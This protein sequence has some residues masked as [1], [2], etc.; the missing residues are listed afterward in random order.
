[1]TTW[2]RRI[3]TIFTLI[4]ML[5][6]GNTGLPVNQSS[7]T[8][9]AE[10]TCSW[11]CYRGDTRRTGVTHNDCGP[12]SANLTFLW[13]FETISQ[14]VSSPAIAESRVVI[15][16]DDG[17]VHCLEQS[18]GEQLWETRIGKDIHSSPA[19]AMG[20]IFVGSEDG[21]M[22]C[23]DLETGEVVWSFK[24]EAPIHS[25]PVVYN[26]RLYFGSYDFNVYCISPIDG[27]LIWKYQTYG[28]VF[29]SPAV[30]EER[31]YIGSD[32]GKLYCL[33]FKTGEFIWDFETSKK[34]D[35]TPVFVNDRIVFASDSVFCLRADTG[36]LYW[37]FPIGAYGVSSCA[38]A[39]NSVTVCRWDGMLFN[40]GL[41]T[42]KLNW[43]HKIN[44]FAKAPSICADRIYLAT[45][46]GWFSSVNIYD[47]DVI[48]EV[49]LGE[50][51]VGNPAISDGLVVVASTNGKAYCY[52]DE[53]V[54]DCI[55]LDAEVVDFGSTASKG[56][57]E[58][59]VNI[60]NC[61]TNE[62]DLEYE[63]E[64]KWFG[65]RR[66]PTGPIKVR[67]NRH[68]YVYLKSQSIGFDGVYNGN[69]TL[70]WAGL[71]K[72]LPV[73]VFVDNQKRLGGDCQ[74]WSHQGG[75]SGAG[76]A[77]GDCSPDRKKMSNHWRVEFPDVPISQPVVDGD[78]IIIAR[79]Y[80]SI[81]C[82]DAVLGERL[83][84][85]SADG[86]I[87]VTPSIY[88]GKVFY[89][90]VNRELGCLN[91]DD[92]ARIWN[93]KLHSS[94]TTDLRAWRDRIFLANRANQIV[95]VDSTTGDV[96]ERFQADGEITGT[97]ALRSAKVY[98]GTDRG[99]LY[100]LS[101]YDLSKPIWTINCIASIT[102][103][104]S[105][106][107][108]MC[109]FGLS[110][111]VLL[112]VGSRTGNIVWEMRLGTWIEGD[113]AVTDDGVYCTTR[114]NVLYALNSRDGEI[115]WRTDPWASIVSGPA[116][117]SDRVIISADR[118]LYAISRK[119]G[120]TV[121]VG[122]YTREIRNLSIASGKIF[123]CSQ[124][125]NLYCIGNMPLVTFSPNLINFGSLSR[126]SRKEYTVR[127]TN[128]SD[129]DVVVHLSTDAD[130]FTISDKSI[131]LGPGG[132][133][134][135]ILI[136]I[137]YKVNDLG[138][139]AGTITASWDDDIC[140]LK[141]WAY[142]QKGVSPQAWT[143]FGGDQKNSGVNAEN[144]LP[145]KD[146]EQLWNYTT[147]APILSSPVLDKGRL[148]FGSNDTDIRC[149]DSQL[150][151]LLWSFNT[152]G[153]IVSTCALAN[154][155][156]F[157][158]SEDG[159]LY[160]LDDST[161][162]LL[163]DYYASGLISSVVTNSPSSKLTY[164]YFGSSHGGA[165]CLSV[166]NGKM[167]VKW[168]VDLEGS[169]ISAPAID[170]TNVIFTGQ[171][172]VVTC[173]SAVDGQTKWKIDIGMTAS[174][175]LIADGM[176]Y[177]QGFSGRLYRLNIKNGK[178]VWINNYVM[179]ITCPVKVG[180]DIVAC[181]I[182]GWIV[183]INAETGENNWVIDVGRPIYSSP[184]TDGKAVIVSDM[185]GTTRI[186]DSYR[187]EELWRH[188]LHLPIMSSPALWEG[189]FY[190]GGCDRRMYCFG[191]D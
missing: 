32:D 186:L 55:S 169:F 73:R 22:Y 30:Y 145:V 180:D 33:D 70:K 121:W 129:N 105:V 18:S 96:V 79:K 164:I 66:F 117:T 188:E 155:M 104:I 153:D 10:Q 190:V 125:R 45:D 35:G 132:T 12:V 147:N 160:C 89:A 167:S 51:I 14:I 187:G 191:E 165:Y 106:N 63:I 103:P 142:V 25:S 134:S 57:G 115:L 50:Q 6:I 166:L 24:T 126:A 154:D 15:G 149:L 71:Q 52:G 44:G 93:T 76:H 174:P 177:V 77:L 128:T 136:T 113:V 172:G 118:R 143:S 59:E 98:F 34:V 69:I 19:Y 140:H 1:M 184:V 53:I 171:K 48:W 151:V 159:H 87:D 144:A 26:Q 58:V 107:D 135:F 178:D 112:N 120:S 123:A 122:D 37:E 158:A 183:S 152:G 27:E 161:G 91:I 111:G 23:L 130:W 68:F 61:G 84:S 163:W 162:G 17:Y 64:G 4:S 2:K 3:I 90:T 119:D 60:R 114:S 65:I 7:P 179:G 41:Y 20:S 156:I 54:R 85:Y 75:L 31:V 95:S 72:V 137:P 8:V 182:N 150:G 38:V 86:K 9:K 157:V 47:G 168:H 40:F 46:E 5:I 92:G 11:F 185:G 131:P 28:E 116:V 49:E 146:L 16:S 43:S 82:I 94:P 148:F 67:H 42:G 124:D 181:G 101:A 109:C 62:I 74:W 83:W 108:G 110:N 99:T 127:V 13:E 170:G 176:V 175:P 133:D 173:L 138:M 189:R 139:R 78:K 39:R 102:T 141:T 81:D 88:D 100:C 36:E 97:P 80:G 29:S 21:K 56:R